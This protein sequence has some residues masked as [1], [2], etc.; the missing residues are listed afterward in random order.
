[1]SASF[2]VQFENSTNRQSTVVTKQITVYRYLA[3]LCSASFKKVLGYGRLCAP[4]GVRCV[5]VVGHVYEL[6]WNATYVCTMYIVYNYPGQAY[7]TIHYLLTSMSTFIECTLLVVSYMLNF[8]ACVD[9]VS[10]GKL[11]ECCVA[12]YVKESIGRQAVK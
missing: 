4:P 3:V 8:M 6:P 9:Q 1:M 7:Y 2:Q 11:F 12:Y 10:G 5:V